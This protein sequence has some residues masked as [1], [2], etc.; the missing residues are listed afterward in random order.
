MSEG[1]IIH[2]MIDVCNGIKHLHEKGI[3]HRDIKVENILLGGKSFK[4]CDFGSASTKT[5]DPS[6]CTANHLDDM[7]EDFEKYTTMMYRPPEMIDKYMKYVVDTQ[8]DVWMLGC[9]LFSLCFFMH[10]F[11]DV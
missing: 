7:M 9:V 3:A 6:Q 4:L 8:A 10:P 11:Q 1:Q 5:L 2:I